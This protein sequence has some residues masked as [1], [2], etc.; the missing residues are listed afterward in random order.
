MNKTLQEYLDDMS[1]PPMEVTHEA[2]VYMGPE[3]IQKMIEWKQR[4]GNYMMRG[5]G[6]S[7]SAVTNERIT[8]D[9]F[10]SIKPGDTVTL[11]NNV[12]CK[13]VKGWHRPEGY[14]E[15]RSMVEIEPVDGVDETLIERHVIQ[16][17]IPA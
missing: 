16:N 17:I 10:H 2:S 1:L 4:L 15:F 14:E 11:I 7:I 6:I 12:V 3:E 8:R 5:V 13:V 9:Q